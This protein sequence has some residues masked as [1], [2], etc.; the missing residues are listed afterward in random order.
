MALHPDNIQPFNNKHQRHGKWIAYNI[1]N[2]LVSYEGQFLNGNYHGLWL[3]YD[4]DDG[5]LYIKEYYI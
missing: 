5:E 4:D 1:H 2:D 3:W